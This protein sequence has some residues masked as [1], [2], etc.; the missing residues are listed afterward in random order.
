M[1]SS[2]LDALLEVLNIGLLRSEHATPLKEGNA[3]LAPASQGK[4]V[5]QVVPDCIVNHGNL[6]HQLHRLLILGLLSNLIEFLLS[7]FPLSL[8]HAEL[9]IYRFYSLYH[10]LLDVVEAVERGQAAGSHCR[11]SA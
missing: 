1:V 6:P 10:T 5:E 8:E 3:R 4:L 2:L 9:G 7:Y 11:K